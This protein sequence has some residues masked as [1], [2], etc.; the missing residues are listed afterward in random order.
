MINLSGLKAVPEIGE[1]F[2]EYTIIDN[3]IKGKKLNLDDVDRLT[4]FMKSDSI[5]YSVQNPVGVMITMNQKPDLKQKIEALKWDQ[6]L[7]REITLFKTEDHLDTLALMGDTVIKGTASG[8]KMMIDTY[9]DPQ[10]R[11]YHAALKPLLSNHPQSLLTMAIALTPTIKK[12]LTQK[13][14]ALSGFIPDLKILIN[15]GVAGMIDMRHHEGVLRFTLTISADGKTVKNAV[16]NI[17]SMMGMILRMIPLSKD[18]ATQK[19]QEKMIQTLKIKEIRGNFTLS[20]DLDI[21]LLKKY[22]KMM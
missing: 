13:I 2:K 12:E 6:E 7:Y 8:V 17:T 19:H 3:I 15:N 5:K 20:I 1:S 4:F 9:R 21:T 11:G 10:K 16:T 22:L 14:G 18:P